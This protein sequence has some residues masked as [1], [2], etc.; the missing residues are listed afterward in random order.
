MGEEVVSVP[1][2]KRNGKPPRRAPAIA[3]G[4]VVALA[5]AIALWF[6]F[7]ILG[8][9]TGVIAM[10]ATAPEWW[11]ALF[12]VLLFLGPPLAGLFAGLRVGRWYLRRA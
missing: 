6:G 12:L 2:L 5:V 7:I 10:C 1:E 9:A 11:A 4:V 8:S 3:F